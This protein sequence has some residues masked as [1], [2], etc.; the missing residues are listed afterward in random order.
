MKRTLFTLIFVLVA[1]LGLGTL[2]LK[3]GGYVLVYFAG[4]ELETSLVFALLVLLA[5]AA[6]GS[7]V[8]LVFQPLTRLLAPSYWE[9]RRQDKA[10]TS[11]LRSATA[12]LMK[13]QWEKASQRFAKA[14]EHSQWP[15]P[16]LLGAAIAERRKG[17]MAAHYEWLEKAAQQRQGKTLTL[18][19]RALFA[20]L[21]GAPAKA[22]ALLEPQRKS[23]GKNPWFL[24][25]LAEAYFHN[26]DWHAYTEL[27]P[28]LLSYD[29]G[30][31]VQERARQA[32]GE[33]LHRAAQTSQKDQEDKRRH[34]RAQW[35]HMP[36]ALQQ[37]TQ[38]LL[39]YC[40]YL[41]Q[42]GG[43]KEAFTL[44]REAMAQQ[45]REGLLPVLTAIDGKQVSLT[46]RLAVLEGWLKDR[47][48][49]TDVLLCL[50]QVAMQEPEY[51]NS[52]EE[53]LR[54]CKSEPRVLRALAQCYQ[55]QGLHEQANQALWQWHES[56]QPPL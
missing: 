50:A 21:D 53:W 23:Q 5:L 39:Q 56:L 55:R 46:D 38:L 16:A 4:W 34:V 13:G 15:T 1:A 36:K 8:L 35:Q 26:E 40:G 18:F 14:S 45:W 29:A 41:V 54:Q 7:F 43:G 9:Q 25:L 19:S 33:R 49:N 48:G 2:L 20:L 24:A 51:L 3:D 30:W 22:K 42:L 27:V 10:H 11:L 31:Q 12:A 6:L 17:D 37:D 44:I 47:P 32:W 28:Q 52:A